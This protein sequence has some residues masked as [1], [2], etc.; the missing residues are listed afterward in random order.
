MHHAGRAQ[1]AHCEVEYRRGLSVSRLHC[2]SLFITMLSVRMAACPLAARPPCTTAAPA[3]LGCRPARAVS[4]ISRAGQGEPGQQQAAEQATATPPTSAAPA[5]AA[6]PASEQPSSSNTNG[7]LA[8]GAVGMGVA[9]FLAARLTMGGPSFAA[10]EA[11]SVP[12]DQALQNG[13]CVRERVVGSNSSQR[14]LQAPLGSGCCTCR[15]WSC[16]QAGLP[17]QCLSPLHSSRPCRPT[18]LEFYAGK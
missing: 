4:L 16:L 7:L 14:W 18:V 8:G 11:N 15:M 2:S 13:R 9:L 1:R 5:P 17:V 6:T 3:G 10:L 12:L